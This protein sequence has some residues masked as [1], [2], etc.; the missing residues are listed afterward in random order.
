VLTEPTPRI[1]TPEGVHVDLAG[2]SLSF[3]DVAVATPDGAR[4]APAGLTFT[5]AA[6]DLT[7]LVGPNGEGKSTALL[8][9]GALLG[10]TAGA[11]IARQRDGVEVA[12]E[13]AD[14]EKWLSQCGWVPQRPDLGPEGLTMSLGQRQLAALEKALASG[15]P[16][17]LLDEPTA[18]LDGSARTKL[19]VRLREHAARGATVI[20]ATHD[21]ALI[22]AADVVVAVTASL[23]APLG[24]AA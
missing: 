13:T 11:V 17:L 24:G 3:R 18:H 7:A 4:L 15:R 22:A 1:G 8:V 12:L 16:V 14:A 9:A 10:A 23:A 19:I 6:G 2:A 20:V 21:D 5:A